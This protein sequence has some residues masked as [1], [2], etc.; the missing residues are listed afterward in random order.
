MNMKKILIID[1]DDIFRS[2]LHQL[3]ERSGYEV[4]EAEDG[5]RGYQLFQKHTPH[6]IIT[7]IVMPEKEGIETIREIRGQNETIPIIAVSGGGRLHPDSYLPLAQAM[8]AQKTFSKPFDNHDFLS[9]V[10]ELLP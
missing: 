6:L 9:A 8:G 1:D 10:A 4:F 2:M 3:L 5:R 7:D